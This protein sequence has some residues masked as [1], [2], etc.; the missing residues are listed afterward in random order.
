MGVVK[1]IN[2]RGSIWVVRGNSY[3]QM[4]Y[5]SYLVSL[6]TPPLANS[7]RWLDARMPIIGVE[8]DAILRSR[9]RVPT[10]LRHDLLDPLI[11]LLPVPACLRAA[12]CSVG[13]RIH[14]Q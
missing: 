7:R 14:P 13:Q 11:H 8:Y 4:T 6:W 5:L 2:V 3:S 9:P 12:S 10:F 1:L